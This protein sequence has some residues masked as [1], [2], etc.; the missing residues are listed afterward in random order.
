MRI[1]VD[2]WMNEWMNDVGVDCP[3]EMFLCISVD[4]DEEISDNKED[5]SPVMCCGLWLNIWIMKSGVCSY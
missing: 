1:N 5:A 4:N 3:K 2:E